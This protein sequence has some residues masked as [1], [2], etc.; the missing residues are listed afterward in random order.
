MKRKR[1]FIVFKGRG[2][3]DDQKAV[4]GMFTT[5]LKYFEALG[6]NPEDQDVQIAAMQKAIQT[7]EDMKAEVEKEGPSPFIIKLFLAE[8]KRD[9]LQI[10]KNLKITHHEFSNLVILSNKIGYSHSQETIEILPPDLENRQIPSLLHW[11]G[12]DDL[13][14]EGETDLSE[15]ELKRLISERKV[16]H[17]HSFEKEDIWHCFYFTY[18]DIQGKHFQNLEHVHYISSLWTKSKEAVREN[19]KQKRHAQWGTHITYVHPDKK[20]DFKF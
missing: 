14:H 15:G 3:P 7:W 12:K 5:I 1:E 20:V 8:G 4:Q 19:L 10:T 18:S 2:L 11:N 13:Y 6:L 9:A 17:V 16:M